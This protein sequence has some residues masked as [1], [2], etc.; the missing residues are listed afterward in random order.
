MPVYWFWG[1]DEFARDRAVEQLRDSV[2][3]PGWAAFNSHRLAGEAIIE[4]LNQALTPAFG[5]G[6]RVVWIANA[7]LGRQ[8]SQAVLT[9]LERAL[10][11]IPEST[12]LV[13]TATDKPDRRLR[14]TKLLEQYAQLRQFAAIPPWKTEAIAQRAQQFARQMGMT[15]SANA[16]DCL[17]QSVGN[18]TRQLWSELHKLQLYGETLERPLE[19]A[20]VTALVA[21][22]TQNSLQLAT[23]LRQGDAAQALALIEALLAREEPALRIAATLTGQ[24]RRWLQV[25]LLLEQGERDDRAI[26]T[27]AEVGNPK[28]VYFLRQE[29]QA[30]SS[31]QLSASL[32]LLLALETELKRGADPQ[33]VL[34]A[35]AVEVCRMCGAEAPAART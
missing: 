25:K 33:T 27:A 22:T 7:Q 21:P 30:L 5:T 8:C 10:P 12:H 20:D 23:A 15:L 9:E 16:A 35:K 32:P 19:A 31:Q 2:L 11:Q 18:Q 34:P 26:A 13:L 17:A 29:V 4:G 1:D 6:D 24:F 28:R 14:T 3:D